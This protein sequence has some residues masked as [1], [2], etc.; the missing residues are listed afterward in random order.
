M[1]FIK[2]RKFYKILYIFITNI[3]FIFNHNFQLFY[4]ASIY[5]EKKQP[6]EMKKPPFQA[7]LKLGRKESNSHVQ[8]QSLLSYH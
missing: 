3:A 2:T 6:R 8:I 1:S 4:F 5:S 7:V